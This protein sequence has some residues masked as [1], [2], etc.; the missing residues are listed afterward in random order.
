MEIL[1]YFII[2]VAMLIGGA[3]SQHLFP[4]EEKR[5]DYI[6]DTIYTWSYFRRQNKNKGKSG[7]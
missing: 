2:V 5:N 1:G 3:I 6:T 7:S 4:R